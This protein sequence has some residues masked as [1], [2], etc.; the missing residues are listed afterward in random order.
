MQNDEEND[1]HGYGSKGHDTNIALHIS[2]IQRSF[3]VFVLIDRIFVSIG[4]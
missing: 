1:R 4:S 3:A 2:N